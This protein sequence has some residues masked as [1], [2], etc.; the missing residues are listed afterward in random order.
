MIILFGTI[1]FSLNYES[2][3]QYTTRLATIKDDA[4]EVIMKKEHY[5]RSGSRRIYA[6]QKTSEMILE[7]PLLG[8][9]LETMDP[10]FLLRYRD[11]MRETIGSV[12]RFDRAHNEYLHIAF[13]SGIPALF[14]YLLF[15]GTC[16]INGIRKGRENNYYYPIVFALISYLF[17]AFFN[18][19]VVSVAYIFWI[20]LG[21][22]MN[23]AVFKKV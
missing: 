1:T 9:G 2:G 12:V 21:F 11:D 16:L 6:W 8:H 14:V 5:Q 22:L 15:L 18:I 20:Y 7:R 10:M 3:G 17:A 4:A 19:S 13:C 23:K